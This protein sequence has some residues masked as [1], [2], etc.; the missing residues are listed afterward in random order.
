MFDIP[1]YLLA[2]VTWKEVGGDPNAIDGYALK[3]RNFDHSGDPVLKPLTVTRHPELTSF[4]N[5]SIQLRRAAEILDRKCEN[6][7]DQDAPVELLSHDLMDL[8][9]VAKHLSTLIGVNFAGTPGDDLTAE[10]VIEIATR[11]NRG[12]DLS[13][14]SIQEDTFLDCKPKAEL[15]PEGGRIVT[16][17]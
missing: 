12:P 7:K 16:V 14:K 8:Y 6:S 11:Y 4:G 5:L 13:R 10:Q 17:V 15:M 2:G 9:I 3:V 1:P